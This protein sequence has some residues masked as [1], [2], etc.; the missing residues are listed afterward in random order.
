[1]EYVAG[2]AFGAAVIVS[3]FPWTRFATGSGFAGAWAT[4]L[5]WS[6]LAA[7]AAVAALVV[8]L[9]MTNA[10]KPWLAVEAILGL[11]GALGAGMSLMHPPP[12]KH[13]SIAPGFALAA[14][15]VG[16]TAAVIRVGQASDLHR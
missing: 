2:V 14:L 4:D 1:V 13:A 12:F 8:W 9:F 15:L 11:A 6:M 3:L 10:H 5:R 16:A 7:T